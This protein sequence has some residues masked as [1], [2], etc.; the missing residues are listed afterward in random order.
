MIIIIVYMIC[1]NSYE[2][3]STWAL[4][5]RR[6]AKHI[7]WI[8]SCQ[9][10][11]QGSTTLIH[12]SFWL[13]LVIFSRLLGYLTVV[14]FPQN[15]VALH[16]EKQHQIARSFLCSSYDVLSQCFCCHWKWKLQI[17]NCLRTLASSALIQFDSWSKKVAAPWC[18][19]LS[20]YRQ[21]F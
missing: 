17:I 10:R 7:T 9:H 12:E 11:N 16:A 4:C 2:E 8:I 21:C 13:F 15:S 20:S 14:Q 18:R 19:V 6:I 1:L 3:G 5:H